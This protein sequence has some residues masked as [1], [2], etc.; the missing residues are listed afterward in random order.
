MMKL[1]YATSI[2]FP[3]RLANRIQTL[4]MA[5]AFAAALSER[6][7]FGIGENADSTPLPGVV[8]ESGRVDN[9]S[10]AF[11]F[12][13]YAT[14]NSVSHIYCR[15]EKL[16]FFLVLLAPMLAPRVSF[17][18]ELHHLTHVAAWWHRFLLS[19]VGQVVSITAA[20]RDELV[21]KYGYR[22]MTLV[23]HDAVDAALFT[24][25]LSKEEARRELGLPIDKRIALYAGSL[26]LWKGGG[27]FYESAKHLD[28]SYLLL[29]IGGKPNWVEEFEGWYPRTPRVR[30]LGQK[31]YDT[32]LPRYLRASDVAVL[33][34]TAK[35][36][37]SRIST[38]PLKL[39]A[40]MAAGTP[41]VASD[42]PSLRE[43]LSDRNAVMVAPDDPI[44]LAEGIRR[45]ATEAASIERAAVAREDVRAHSWEARANA[46]LR[47]IDDN[48]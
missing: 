36:H 18:Y 27:T 42:L 37:I 41:I 44:A 20:M 40:Y 21:A 13:Q 48:D 45:A 10:R 38:S 11:R 34:N 46:V 19:R 9:L 26:E 5:R 12:L 35:E 29:I 23:A 32:E 7:V 14:R 24:I 4:A 30:M 1:L 8:I 31:E 25:P 33:P 15:E 28:D 39:F 2:H 16:L 6:F 3:S 47:F 17:C 43:I 22:G